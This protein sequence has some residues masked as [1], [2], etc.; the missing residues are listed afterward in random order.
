MSL[1][2]ERPRAWP[3]VRNAL[4]T[5]VR[6]AAQAGAVAA[7]VG[8]LEEV[9]DAALSSAWEPR[10]AGAALGLLCDLRWTRATDSALTG[11]LG[12]ARTALLDNLYRA[13]RHDA[14]QAVGEED[15]GC[16]CSPNMEGGVEIPR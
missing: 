4:N 15:A 13:L 8:V 9:C 6:K 16:V 10:D 12:D 7:T 5:A 14:R 11:A 3:Q 1:P 2:E